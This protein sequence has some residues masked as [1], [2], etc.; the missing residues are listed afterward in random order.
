MGIR[1]N[2]RA[3]EELRSD[4]EV[5]D[6]ELSREQKKALIREAKQKY[7]KDWKKVLFGAAGKLKV[8]KEALETFHSLGVGGSELRQMNN[9]GRSRLSRYH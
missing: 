3:V 6:Q 2:E 9:P 1:D 8:N 5:L 7:G 4:N